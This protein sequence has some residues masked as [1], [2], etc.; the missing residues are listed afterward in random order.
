MWL[1]GA[2]WASETKPAKEPLSANPHSYYGNAR[3]PLVFGYDLPFILG[4]QKGLLCRRSRVEMYD[5]NDVFSLFS[6]IFFLVCPWFQITQAVRVIKQ[7]VQLTDNRDLGR[8]LQKLLKSVYYPP[9]NLMVPAGPP[10]R[11]R[12]SGCRDARLRK[13]HVLCKERSQKPFD[14]WDKAS[15]VITEGL[16]ERFQ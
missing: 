11:L 1:F 14:K 9:K 12:N 4:K 5:S 6:F 3:V 13:G 16:P 15:Q 7:W 2:K 10:G 8:L